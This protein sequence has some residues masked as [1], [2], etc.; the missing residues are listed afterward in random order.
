MRST[1]SLLASL[2]P[3]LLVAACGG[4]N[5]QG[6][7]FPTPQCSDGM[8]NDGD[9]MTD[10]P[11]D[12][13]CT[14]E[15]DE[16]EDSLTMPQCAD[17][18]DND[19]DGLK[20]YP[21]DPGCIAMQQD[22]ETDDCPNG[23][24][25]PQCADGKDNDG[26]GST[27]FAG[28]DPGCT[29]ASDDDEFVHNPAA[30]G[31]TAL[32]V[33]L[34][35]TGEVMGTFDVTKT[36]PTPLGCNLTTGGIAAVYELY[37][38]TP[39]VIEASTDDSSTTA[40]TV[41]DIRSGD[42]APSTAEVACQDDITS[43]NKKSKVTA[44]LQP[45]LYYIVVVSKTTAGGAYK[46]TVKRYPGEG[47]TCTMPG[48]CGPGL[49]CRIPLGQTAMVCAKPMCSDGV[50][51]DGDTKN[52]YPTDPGCTSPDDNDETDSCPG[53]GPNCP[54]CGDGVDNDADTKTDY[55]NDTTCLSAGDSSESCVTT[56]GVS[57][58]TAAM[59]A[60]DTTLANNDVH[61]SCSSST[62]HT[63]PDRTYRLDVPALASL[64]VNLISPSF[65]T[66]HAL[67]NSTCGGTAINCSD[68]PNMTVAGPIAAGTYYLVV[69][70]YSTGKGT[71]TIA[72]TGT[73]QGNE[74]CE[75]PLALA[76]A[77]TCANG[78]ACA[79]T[80]GSRTCKPAKCNDGIDNDMPA[81]GKIDYPADPGCTSPSDDTEADPATPTACANGADD[82]MDMLTDWPADYGCSAASSTS[83]VFCATEVDPTALITAPVT[84]GTTA[85]KT[86]NFTTTSCVTNPG[87][88]D[89][90][91]AL[92]LPVGL[93]TLVVDTIGT[94]FDTVLTVRD[95]QCTT[96]L[97]CNDD[98]GGTLTSKITMSNVAAGN[99]AVIL[100]GFGTNAGAYTLNVHGTAFPQAVCTTPL[101]TSG[102]LACPMGTTCNAGTGKCQ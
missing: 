98:G 30:C 14:S 31:G 66:V 81:D 95:P 19:G 45:G 8:D 36:T 42:C 100:D 21:Y 79:G 72:I 90:G 32:A 28:N 47:T 84:T 91:Y 17:G 87:G 49:V 53:A 73:I 22:D 29:S 78:F 15:N 96:E 38:T 88:P 1:R 74:S 43:T 97:S 63:A 70:G 59:T 80:M 20:D 89:V 3:L 68:S 11:D 58:L 55:P 24:L 6:D 86:N 50:D 99:Y 83:E 46:L 101:F 93:Q 60:G 37:L 18:R 62:T 71:Y 61:P 69:D 56:D 40:D 5:S 7:D 67:F 94:G 16:T 44:A 52:D 39:Q 13:G 41:I 23:P 10:Y 51:D 4:K 77:L 64:N 35:T 33:S 85:G 9:G 65:D 92:A 75:S 27:D 102:V 2:L 34:P 12:L 82:D 25:C 57:L 54:E 26:N 48:D 76:G